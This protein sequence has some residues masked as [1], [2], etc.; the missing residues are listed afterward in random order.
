MYV[1]ADQDVSL[2]EIL[3]VLP[4]FSDHRECVIDGGA[5]NADKRLDSGVGIHVGKVGLHDIACCKPYTDEGRG[6]RQH[7]HIGWSVT[8]EFTQ[9]ELLV[10]FEI[11]NF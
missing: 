9:Y 4:V 7:E 5:Q 3:L 11:E 2:H 1:V 10:N 6:H 8:E